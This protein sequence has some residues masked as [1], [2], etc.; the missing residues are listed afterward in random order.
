MQDPIALE[1]F[2][3]DLI[4]QRLAQAAQDALAD[5]LPRA[6]S[7]PFHL[8]WPMAGSFQPTTVARQ[9]LAQALRA[10]ACRLDD[11]CTPGEAQLAVLNTR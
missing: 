8:P 6:I 9:H 4:R 10:L 7:A 2:A 1:V 5:Q 11:A 3:H